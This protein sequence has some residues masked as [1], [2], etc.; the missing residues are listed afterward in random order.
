MNKKFFSLLFLSLMLMM[1]ACGSNDNDTPDISKINVELTPKTIKCSAAGGQYDIKV[2]TDATEWTAYSNDKWAAVTADTKGG[3]IK[4]N[5]SKN[6][7]GISRSTEI[8]FKSKSTYASVT[9]NQSAPLAV[10][11]SEVFSKADGEKFK[12]NVTTDD[13]WTATASDTWITAARNGNTVEITT[14]ENKGEY[15]IGT[16]TVATQTETTDITVKQDAKSDIVCPIAGYRLVWNDEF[17]EG[18]TLNPSKW[19]HEVQKQGWVNNELQNY[20]NGTSPSGARV[21]EIKDGRLLIH[22]FKENGKVYSG[23]VYGNKSTGFTYGVFEARIKLPSGKG[24]W[25]AWWMMPVNFTSWPHCGEI[26][27]MEEVG[28][29]PNEVSSS[30]HCTAYNHVKGT[31]KTHAMYCAGAEGEFHTYTLEWTEDYIKTWVDGKEQLV[32]MNDKKNND[33]T[34]PFHVAFYPILNLA[35]GG[36]WGGYKGVDDSALPVTMEVDYVRVFQK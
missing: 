19:V 21:T 31:Q 17:S 18:T 30:I 24:T 9:L 26:D 34:W 2:K 15:R 8:H 13:E 23:R 1:T 16:V 35:W 5:V 11:L 36:M 32:F 4:V 10:E 3:I 27:I 29:D 33:D 28:A 22:C 12:V 20:V 25:P 14:A 6:E 7:E